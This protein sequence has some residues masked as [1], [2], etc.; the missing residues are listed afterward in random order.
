LSQAQLGSPY[1]TRAHVSAIELGKIRPAMKSLEHMAAKL[2]KAASYFLEG[3][4]GRTVPPRAGVRRRP[5]DRP[6][7]A[8]ELRRS[9]SDKLINSLEGGALS[10]HQRSRLHL[11]RARALNLSERPSEA[12]RDLTIAQRLVAQLKDPGLA[13]TIDCELAAATRGSGRFSA[14][15]R[16][17]SRS[18]P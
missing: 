10:V 13:N 8:D 7:V 16:L 9:A 14:C 11:A 18:P 17:V 3:R 15:T 12:L 6:R 4:H 1:Y 5:H 2:G